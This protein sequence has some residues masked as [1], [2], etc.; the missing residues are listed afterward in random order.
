MSWKMTCSTYWEVRQRALAWIMKRGV[1][2][3]WHCVIQI[4][5]GSSS[6]FQELNINM[7]NLKVYLFNANLMRCSNAGQ[8]LYCHQHLIMCF[9]FSWSCFLLTVI[10]ERHSSCVRVKDGN[11]SEHILQWL[12]W[13]SKATRFWHGSRW[14]SSEINT[15]SCFM[16]NLTLENE[17]SS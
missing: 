16:L 6:A 13:F 3:F 10:P 17:F 1:I 12:T 9:W 11:M 7:C 2:F 5:T 14:Q 8:L 15:T 4:V